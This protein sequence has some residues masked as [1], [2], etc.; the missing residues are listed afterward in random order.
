[1][2]DW[3]KMYEILKYEAERASNTQESVYENPML[4][5]AVNYVYGILEFLVDDVKEGNVSGFDDVTKKIVEQFAEWHIRS[6]I[7]ADMLY[8][9]GKGDIEYKKE[10]IK[11]AS[12]IFENKAIKEYLNSDLFYVTH[13][14]KKC[15]L[16]QK[17]CK[18]IFQN[19][20]N[21]N[22][23]FVSVE[24]DTEEEARLE[25]FFSVSEEHIK[26]E[27]V[28][29]EILSYDEYVF[30]RLVDTPISEYIKEI[31]RPYLVEY[32]I[33]ARDLNQ[34]QRLFL[35]EMYQ[36]R[37][38]YRAALTDETATD[39]DNIFGGTFIHS[40]SPVVYQGRKIKIIDSNVDETTLNNIK[41]TYDTSSISCCKDADIKKKLEELFADVR[42][43]TTRVY[44]VGNG[45]C[46]YNYGKK[47]T[48][49]TRFF[50]DIGFDMSAYIGKNP[51]KRSK[52]QYI[53]ALYSIGHMKPECVILSHWDEDHFRA[54]VYA[55]KAVFEK[56]W[57]APY[58]YTS[59]NKANAKRLFL[60]LYKIG[61]LMVVQRGIARD[62]VVQHGAQ[63]T[64]TLFVG[65]RQPG[66]D[67][68]ITKCNCEGIALYLE[69]DTARYGKIKCLMQG[70]V[71]YMSLP[72][73]TNFAKENPYT[74]LVAPH[75][76]AEMD[77]SML[78]GALKKDGQAVICCT[79][80]TSKNRPEINHLNALT[81][82]YDKVECTETASH[83]IQF[84]LRKKKVMNIV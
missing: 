3:E 29:A 20:D 1:M 4:R 30:E 51:I 34:N 81:K 79:N 50:Y 45:N 12:E 18:E 17:I 2:E 14:I 62:I 7:K 41:K 49:E 57:V 70:D 74:Y 77:C 55:N 80:D 11:R 40:A 32:Y 33:D 46:I 21:N 60:Y 27:V 78:M 19:M 31:Y 82:C 43:E 37:G 47:G 52:N 76:G 61:S 28:S 63:R 15:S 38:W 84:D 68:K 42:F 69:N 83:Y 13:R 39:E 65:K 75:H 66:T 58:I 10:V 53:K 22:E 72:Q 44:K 25:E 36:N 71:P 24:R 56:K 35:L 6:D 23:I 59:E 67:K 64:M 16:H 5:N 48:K 54:C 9:D 73:Q 26:L 8:G